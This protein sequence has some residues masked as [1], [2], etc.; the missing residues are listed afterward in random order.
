MMNYYRHFDRSRL[1]IDFVVHGDGEGEYDEEIR[2]LGGKIFH[3]PVKSRHPLAYAPALR[4]IF[5]R[6][7]SVVHTHTD[8]M[9]AWILK[10]AKECGVPVR[11]AH[12][13]NTSHA[14]KTRSSTRS[15]NTRVKTLRNTPPIVLPVLK[16]RASGCSGNIPSP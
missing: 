13:H 16:R 14:T 12:S 11:I 4:K 10:I 3:V 9:G 1:Q 8:A 5:A 7:Y 2:S 6:G 15:T